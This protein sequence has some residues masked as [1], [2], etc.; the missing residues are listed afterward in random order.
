M[1][2]TRVLDQLFFPILKLKFPDFEN[3]YSVNEGNHVHFLKGLKKFIK[4]LQELDENKAR[5]NPAWISGRKFSSVYI[6]VL[7]DIW[8][9]NKVLIEDFEIT[10]LKL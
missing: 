7:A 8:E 2:Y 3:I 1:L 10:I 6:I 9:G 5:P 4:S